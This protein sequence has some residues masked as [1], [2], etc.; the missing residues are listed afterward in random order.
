MISENINIVKE[1][2][3]SRCLK[4]GRSPEEVRIIAVSKNTGLQLIT[5]ALASGI[6]DLGENKAQEMSEKMHLLEGPINWHFLGHLQRNKVKTVVGAAYCI[7]SVDSLRLAEEINMQAARINHTQKILL[8]VKTSDEV[9]KYGISSFDELLEIASFCREAA[10][11]E[12]MGLMTMAP[13]S[14]DEKK[15]RK[16]FT[17]LCKLKVTLNQQGFNLSELS[18]GMTNDF[19]IAVEEGAT[20]VRVGTA[21]FGER[22]YSKS[23][24]EQ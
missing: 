23:W 12:L 17:D 20:M 8:E 24:R 5:Q 10:N 4:T 16:S 9:T 19:E 18:M 3:V 21:I 22:D 6:H 15:I 14:E 13:Y 1:K 11:L 2:I 7:H